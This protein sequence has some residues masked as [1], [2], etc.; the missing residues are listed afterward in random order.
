ME[1][2]D[3]G[4]TPA[5]TLIGASAPDGTGIVHLGLGSFHRAHLAVHTARAL[6]VE[7]GPWGIHGFA[8]RS[9]RV[10]EALRAQDHRYA[11]LQLSQDGTSAGV[12]DVHRATGVLAAEPE[13]FIRSLARPEH[14]ILSLTVSEVGYSLAVGGGLD[15]DDPGIRADLAAPHEPRTAIGLIAR[16]LVERSA[17]GAP[18][19]VLSCDNLQSS[20]R[21][22]ERAITEF[23]QASGADADALDYVARHVAF[24]NAMVDRIVPATT[25]ATV[26]D[27]ERLLGVH[28]AAPVPA[29][30][31][32]MWVL[33]DRFAAG[34][35]AW[36]AAGAT[37]SDEVEAYE[38]VKLRLLNG[39]HS[40]I[41]YL[42]GLSGAPTI[43]ES[44][45]QPWVRDAVLELIRCDYLPTI[46]L[47][48]GL[49]VDEYVAS[50]VARWSNAP[51]RDLTARV[52]S[53]GSTKLL[54][55]VPAP[56]VQTLDAGRTPHLLALTTAAWIACVAPP[57]GFEPGPVAADMVEPAREQLA[58]ATRGAATAREH[59]LAALDAGVLPAS[60]AARAPF[61]ERVAELVETIARHGARAAAEDA[62]RASAEEAR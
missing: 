10:V 27:V 45:A 49:D 57:S 24:P 41:A 34:R 59:A 5:G 53:G 61:R 11:V 62:L 42:G 40:L 60:L 17:S 25:P 8:N 26:A 14:R 3:A 4:T 18:I 22:T 39:S 15:L 36:H 31:F 7:Q 55:R 32:S 35:P 58:A 44:F 52:G 37:M 16:G 54:Q 1:R 46:T 28:D 12:V 29:E 56:A 13:A 6:A 20:G 43:V 47:P 19:T 21:T 2:L 23:L 51:L 50:L 30:A 9:A 33:E 38:L 48:E